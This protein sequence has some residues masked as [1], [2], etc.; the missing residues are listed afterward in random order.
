MT[1]KILRIYVD[2]SVFYGPFAQKFS[3]ETKPFWDAVMDGKIRIVLSDVLT[4][5]I[6]RSA[7][8]V[9]DFYGSL[10][11]SL[12]E[13]V[14][15]TDESDT[16]AEQYVTEKVVGQASLTDCKH[17]ALATIARTDVLVSWN[18]KHLANLNRKRGYN[19]VNMKL[20]YPQIEI[21]TP[22]MVIYD[23]D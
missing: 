12:I 5:E 9:R 23:E 8:N 11:E 19:G 3:Q 1:K 20:G 10:P 15:S 16:L 7:K 22:N 14:F 18:M 6:E 4:D 17:V 13:R 2:T 21:L